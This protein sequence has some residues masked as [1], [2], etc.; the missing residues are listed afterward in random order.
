LTGRHGTEWGS[1]MTHPHSH[2]SRDG[3]F[4]SLNTAHDGRVDV[5]VLEI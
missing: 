1:Q 5:C 3:R 2:D 4:V